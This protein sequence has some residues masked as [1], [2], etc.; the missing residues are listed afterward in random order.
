MFAWQFAELQLTAQMNGWTK[1]VSMQNHYNLIYRE[2]ER[3][4][5][6][7][8]AKTGVA[9][10]PWSPLAR[11]ILA[12]AYKGSFDEGSTSRSQGQDRSRTQSLYHGD[13]IFDIADRVMEMAEKYG[14]TPAQIAVAW[15]LSKPEVTSP[16]V[17]V[18]KV[19]QL[20]QLVAAA[21]IELDDADVDYLEALYQ[22]VANLLTL[23]YS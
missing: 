22:P 7:Y 17:G 12:G 8:C 15:L 6:P 18:S 1:F 14:H 16:V 13:F 4:M 5:N 21:A 23:G 19:S 10:M 11:G 2:E 20:E 9:L 3:E